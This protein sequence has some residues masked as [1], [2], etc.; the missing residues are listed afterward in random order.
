MSPSE[1]SVFLITEK[2]SS[3]G[4]CLLYIGRGIGGC[5][6]EVSVECWFKLKHCLLPV[7]LTVSTGVR[8]NVSC[9][10][11]WSRRWLQNG[12]YYLTKRSVFLGTDSVKMWDTLNNN[13]SLSA[14]KMNHLHTT[15]CE[16][17]AQVLKI[18]NSP[19]SKILRYYFLLPY[20]S[21]T[22]LLEG[23]MLNFLIQCIYLITLV[24][25]DFANCCIRA[26]VAHF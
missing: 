12:S 3:A 23:H 1:T 8:T 4:L 11:V 18:L 14:A 6:T 20:S 21:T 13:L 15:T 25:S 7:S 9:W 2:H 5:F 26:G 17:K 19:L 10:R 22:V 16:Y 24:T